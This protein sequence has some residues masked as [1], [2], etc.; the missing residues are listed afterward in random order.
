MQSPPAGDSMRY[1]MTSFG[2]LVH[3]SDIVFRWRFTWGTVWKYVPGRLT[4]PPNGS[5]AARPAV[6]SCSTDQAARPGAPYHRIRR[7]S[8]WFRASWIILHCAFR[9]RG[10]TAAAGYSLLVARAGRD[11]TSSVKPD[12]LIMNWLVVPFRHHNR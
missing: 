9:R 7:H 11:L 2:R 6:A 12:A 3:S 4:H 8:P 1:C 10:R 5:D